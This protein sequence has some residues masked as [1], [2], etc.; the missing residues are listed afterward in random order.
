MRRRALCS[1]FQLAANCATA[2]L[3]PLRCAA[4]RQLSISASGH[5][6]GLVYPGVGWVLWRSPDHLPSSLLFHESYLG[7]DQ[8]T[9]TLNFSRPAAQIIA[10]YYQ[11][12]RGGGGGLVGLPESVEGVSQDHWAVPARGG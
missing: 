1:H 5:K 6:Y 7:S 2:E 12:G 8:T 3:R 9:L 10:Q 4:H 11:V